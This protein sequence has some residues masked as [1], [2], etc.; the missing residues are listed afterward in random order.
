M[1]WVRVLPRAV[2]LDANDAMLR[3]ARL[4]IALDDFGTG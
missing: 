2:I 1:G 4:T 3:Q